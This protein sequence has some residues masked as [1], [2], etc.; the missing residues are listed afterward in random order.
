VVGRRGGC[1]LTSLDITK[2]GFTNLRHAVN[3]LMDQ[4]PTTVAPDDTDPLRDRGAERLK[5]LDWVADVEVRLREEG[6]I[7]FGEAFVVPS[8][9][10]DLTERIEGALE[11]T[12]ELDWKI[13]NLTIMPV[14]SLPEG[15]ER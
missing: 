2:D 13:H 7:Y 10:S 3:D 8:D 11:R 15:K 5:E 14:R 9:S 6:Q 12:R 4:T 1:G